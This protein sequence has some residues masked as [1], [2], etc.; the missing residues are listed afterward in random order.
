MPNVRHKYGDYDKVPTDA[1]VLAEIIARQGPS[2]VLEALAES[3]GETVV[4]H[5]LLPHEVNTIKFGMMEELRD[6]INERT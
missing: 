4:K 2:L 5:N 6:A 1:K 3:V